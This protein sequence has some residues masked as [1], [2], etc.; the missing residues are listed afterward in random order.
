MIDA[1]V[2]AERPDLEIVRLLEPYGYGLRAKLAYFARL[3]RGSYHLRRSP[4]VVVDNAWLPIHLAPHAARTTV[5]QVWHASGALKRFGLDTVVPPTEPERSFIHRYYDYVVVGGE[6]ARDPYSRA[7]RT[8]I[9][10]VLPLG[11][12]RT[13]RLVDVESMARARAGVLAAHPALRA[14]RVVLYA[15]TFRG[16]GRLRTSGATLDAPR[17]RALLPDS[18]ALALKTHPNLD[19]ALTPTVGYDAVLDPVADIED[20]FAV[21]DVFVTDYSSAVFDWAIL[22]R[23]LVLLV[24]DLDAYERDPGLYLDMRTEMIGTRVETTDDVASAILEDR[25][26]L[27]GYDAFIDRHLSASRGHAT[28]AFVDRFVETIF[29]RRR[30]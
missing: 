13:D 22:R 24:P 17:L 9:E 30:A 23:P 25:F 6:F 27:S 26:D 5:V 15:P 3:V 12:P 29:P 8:P 4:L 11:T 19:P 16:R 20:A 18:W 7:L 14:R 28:E 10:R 2:R 21:A 1:A